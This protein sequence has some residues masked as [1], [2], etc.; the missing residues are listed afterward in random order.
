MDEE[1]TESYN[2]AKEED[3]SIPRWAK[4]LGT[5]L[6]KMPTKGLIN[7]DIDMSEAAAYICGNAL[8]N[9]ILRLFRFYHKQR[10]HMSPMEYMSEMRSNKHGRM[11]MDGLVPYTGEDEYGNLKMPT[12]DELQELFSKKAKTEKWSGGQHLLRGRPIAMM[13]PVLNFLEEIEKVL[14]FLVKAGYTPERLGYLIPLSKIER[15]EDRKVMRE[16]LSSFVQRALKGTYP[17]MTHY[18]YFQTGLTGLENVKLIPALELYYAQRPGK[19]NE[20]L[21]LS[22]QQCGIVLPEMLANKVDYTLSNAVGEAGRGMTYKLRHLAPNMSRAE[23]QQALDNI[24]DTEGTRQG[25]EGAARA[26][27]PRTEARRTET[28]IGTSQPTSYGPAPSSAP[29]SSSSAPT[30]SSTARVGSQQTI[31]PKPRPKGAAR[32]GPP[33]TDDSSTKRKKTG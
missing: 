25:R 6:K 3:Q 17:N 27:A 28:G 24:G 32:E 29:A 26:P 8:A 20:E 16:M 14:E 31:A 4:N 5:D 19:R 22:A 33:T 21:L 7:I 11:D 10:V 23:R 2:K 13:R 1:V 12:D 18:T 15:A 30:S 9:L